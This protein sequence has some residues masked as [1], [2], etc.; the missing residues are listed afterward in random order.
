MAR[1]VRAMNYL[2]ADQTSEALAELEAAN[3]GNALVQALLADCYA[4]MELPAAAAGK[5]NEFS[6]NRQ[7]NL[8]NMFL[9]FPYLLVGDM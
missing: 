9:A 4:R 5:R 6:S 8:A 1:S 7:I 2:A 3:P